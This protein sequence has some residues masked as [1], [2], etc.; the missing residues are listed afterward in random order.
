MKTTYD[1]SPDRDYVQNDNRTTGT[2]RAVEIRMALAS[3]WD[4]RVEFIGYI[5]EASRPSAVRLDFNGTTA[6]ESEIHR[7]S[8]GVKSA[9]LTPNFLGDQNAEAGI[10][11]DIDIDSIRAADI[12][13]PSRSNWIPSRGLRHAST[14]DCLHPLCIDFYGGVGG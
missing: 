7:C 2:G 3:G 12:N 4:K 5:D 6:P 1:T 9:E 14:R 8:R 11:V 13:P 10:C